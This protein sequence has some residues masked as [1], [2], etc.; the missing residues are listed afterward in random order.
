MRGGG[1]SG[2]PG[3]DLSRRAVTQTF[4]TRRAVLDALMLKWLTTLSRGAAGFLD[5][6]G[7][8]ESFSF[9]SFLFCFVLCRTHK[10][11]I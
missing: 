8:P 9:Y 4:S 5:L 6:S 10:V 7:L 2:T 1:V 11:C 3:E